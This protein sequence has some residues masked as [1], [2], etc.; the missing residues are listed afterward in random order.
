M[1]AGVEATG[2]EAVST[3]G[4]AQRLRTLARG[5]ETSLVVLAALIGVLAG[6]SVTLISRGAELLHSVLFGA[7]RISSIPR[8]PLHVL[9]WPAIGGLIMGGVILALKRWRPHSIVDPIEANALHGGRMSLP[10]SIILSLQTMLANGFGASVGMEAGYTQ[11]G[12]GL[13]SVIGQWLRLR[14]MDLRILVGCGAAG[15]IAAAFQAP[16]TG[17]F[18]GFELIIGVYAIPAAAPVMTSALIAY[19]T[20]RQLG[21]ASTPIYVPEIGPL[22][23]SAYLPFLLLGLIAGGVAIGIMR[24]VT[25]VERGF[26]RS[27]LPLWLRPAVGGLGVGALAYV[28]PQVLSSG[29]GALRIQVGTGITSAVAL[30]L[31]LKVCASSLSLGSGFRGGLFFS[32][33]FMGSLLGKLFANLAGSL[34]PWLA[35][36]PVIAAVVG[37]SALAVGVVG[38]PFTMTFLTLEI[39]GDLHIAGLVLTASI[40]CS[41]L[42]RE[43]FGYSFSTWRLHLR[44]ETIRSALDVGWLRALTV[45]RMM[46]TDVSVFG[47][48]ADLAAFRAAFPL[49]SVKTVALQDGEGRYVGLVP[50]AVAH[51]DAHPPTE[52]IEALACNGDD[53]LLADMN[54]K[55]A[56]AVFDRAQIDELVVVDHAEG[57]RIIG[58]LSEAFLLRRYADELD[59]ARRGVAGDA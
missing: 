52:R 21:A 29:E 42:V 45:E 49:G 43:T 33:L 59:K 12:S 51:S 23:P 5:R 6:L 46:R 57:R 32:S 40:G 14:R 9:L 31:L 1:S 2:T 34:V 50:V 16:L 55:Q 58:L 36:D 48:G 35:L 38:G 56:A 47:A 27:G 22:E 39:T 20:A 7:A 18:Y 17:A 54:V 25:L 41:L 24:L 53:I 30:I 28:S 11:S 4:F 19:L 26:A 44:G 37:M 10:D 3:R 15:G 8:L 13:A